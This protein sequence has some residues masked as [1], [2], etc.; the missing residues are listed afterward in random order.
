MKSNIT[1]SDI[2]QLKKSTKLT[3]EH[4]S[5]PRYTKG[6]DLSFKCFLKTGLDLGMEEKRMN[7]EI[8][9]LKKHGLRPFPQKYTP[10][11]LEF[12]NDKKSISNKKHFTGFLE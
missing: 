1:T 11:S 12:K 8:Y 9:K 2:D 5:L 4:Y 10:T 3:R 6:P 7:V